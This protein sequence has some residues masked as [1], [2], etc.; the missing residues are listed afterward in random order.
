MK[1]NMMFMVAMTATL[2][3]SL[4]G[5]GNGS[6]TA[7]QADTSSKVEIN[8]SVSGEYASSGMNIKIPERYE[9]EADNVSFKA[10]VI[11]S[12]EVRE[13]G[14]QKISASVQRPDPEKV[15]ECLMGD[16]EI[17]EKNEEEDNYWYVGANG[18]SLTINNTSIG[19]ATKFYVYVSNAFR[20][21]QGYSDYNADKY[22]LDKDFG[23]ASRQQ[24]FE[25]VRQSLQMM[26]ID[27]ENE[28]KCYVLEHS[29]L[30]S[31]EYVMDMNGNVDQ[32]NY[33]GSWTQD[34]DSYYFVINQKYGDTPAYHVFY[35]NFPLIADENAPIQVL[36][37]KNGIQFLQLEKVF[38]FSEQEGIYDL[39]PFEEIVEVIENKY[40]ML[41]DGS[42]YSVNQ[43]T[44]YY[45]ENETSDGQYAVCPVWIF[46]IVDN[47]DGKALQDVVNAQTGEEI[48]WEEK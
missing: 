36:Y 31:E 37:N 42:T 45:M 20:L 2:C 23:F 21:Q 10:D 22:E 32:S 38:S 29:I 35:D 48:I 12:S 4:S 30:Q 41:L 17:D 11:V 9:K 39:K 8:E 15:L 44:L 25:D 28:Y 46:N 1:K 40:G 33:K 27:V 3:L 6:E 19:F 24:A 7:S 47:E 43:A 34:D 13:N 5:C 14:L 26:G 18:E 16:A